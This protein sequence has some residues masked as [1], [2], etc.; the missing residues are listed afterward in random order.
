MFS[1]ITHILPSK[2]L[3]RN[4]E[5]SRFLNAQEKDYS[6]ALQE[7]KN[8]CKQSHWIWYIFPQMKGL[9]QSEMSEFYGIKSRAEAVAYLENKIL[10]ERLI[11]I[12]EA[13]LT[14]SGEKT[15]WEIFGTIDAIKVRSCMTLFDAISPNDIY[16]R[17]LHDFYNDEHCEKTLLLLNH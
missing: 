6:L 11:E 15:A 4:G 3:V 10:R 13:L 1:F 9:G 7:V 14:H 2:I 16:A 17:V 12:T 8:G 5:I